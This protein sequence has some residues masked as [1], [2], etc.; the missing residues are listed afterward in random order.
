M[1]KPRSWSAD[2]GARTTVRS[3]SSRPTSPMTRSI[4]IPTA[5]ETA[6]AIPPQRPSTKARP[7]TIRLNTITEIIRI[8]RL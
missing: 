5:K 3:A 6:P 8:C 1:L 4:S 7:G 2:P